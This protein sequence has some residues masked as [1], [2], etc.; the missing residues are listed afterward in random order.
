PLQVQVKTLRIRNAIYGMQNLEEKPSRYKNAIDFNYVGL[1]LSD[2]NF[3]SIRWE[4]DSLQAEIKSLVLREKSG[5]ELKQ[6]HGKLRY[7]PETIGLDNYYLQTGRSQLANSL[8]ILLPKDD[9]GKLL[10]DRIGI[11]ASLPQ[12]TLTVAEALYFAP[13]LREDTALA[14]LWD[15]QLFLS[16]RLSGNLQALLLSQ[17]RIRDNV[18]NDINLQGTLRNLTDPNRLGADLGSIDIRSGKK[19]ILSWLTPQQLPS[20]IELA[21]HIH[22]TGR[23]NGSMKKFSTDLN[24]NSSFGMMKASGQVANLDNKQTASYALELREFDMD[25]GKWMKDSTIGRLNIKGRLNGSGLD[26]Q[27]MKTNLDLAIRAA[28]WNGYN[29][30]NIGV[31]GELN[32]GAYKALVESRDSNFLATV[33]LSGKLQDSSLP[34]I[35]GRI[36]VDRADLHKVGLSTQPMIVKGLFDLDLRSTTPRELEGE[37]LVHQVQYADGEKQYQLDSIQLIARR[38]SGMQSIRLES[39][40]GEASLTG[41]YD[42]T[43][44]ANTVSG[45]IT[46]HMEQDYEN[47]RTYNDSTGRQQAVL[48]AS[49]TI[50]KSLKDLVPDLDM[51][52]PLLI[53]GRINTDSSMFYVFARQPQ[54]RYGTARVDSLR[55]LVYAG[56]DSLQFFASVRAVDH[57]S[58]PLNKTRFS[59]SGSDGRINWNFEAADKEGK[60]S[61]DLGGRLD[62]KNKNEFSLSLNPELLLNKT[63]FTTNEDNV[64]VIKNGALNDAALVISS[65]AQSIELN[66]SKE[67]SARSNTYFLTIKDFQGSTISS[68]VSK[69]TSLVDGLINAQLQYRADPGDTSLTGDLKI[70]SLHVFAKPVGALEAKFRQEGKDIGVDAKLTENGNNVLINGKYGETLNAT[71]K[72]DSLQMATIEPFS[73]GSLTDMQGALTGELAVSGAISEPKLSGDLNFHSATMR[74][75]YLNNP[76]LLDQQTISFREDA[77]QLNNFT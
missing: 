39:P 53:N 3:S 12:S 69:D 20:N 64:V 41:D 34:T 14:K 36:S 62:V 25:A 74:V 65:G 76:V 56:Q 27:T 15:K 49:L 58:L 47:K 30:Q 50:P 26:P 51:S 4:D 17:F 44:L 40:F 19:S 7:N 10:T 61:Y 21:E 11:R 1:S 24:L 63:S 32:Q 18:G 60:R 43:Q 72:L 28:G 75:S 71:I 45:L 5:F 33:D 22:L 54:L 73:F 59:G 23:L 48:R 77:I 70:D 66:H 38:D 8:E 35:Q 9:S 31:K 2:A 57:P 67:D 37:V 55:L 52:K 68:F 13:E 6:A 46:Y 29:Y 16:G 42:Y